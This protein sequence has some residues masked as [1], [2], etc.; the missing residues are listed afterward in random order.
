MKTLLILFFATNTF[1]SVPKMVGK[2][3]ILTNEMEFIYEP[4]E[5]GPS[6]N[7]THFI[8]DASNPY[9]HTV[10]CVEE[11]GV[12][13]EFTAHLALSRYIHPSSPEMSY[14]LLYW[15]NNNGATT[16]FNFDKAASLVNIES[17][18]SITGEEAGLRLKLNLNSVLISKQMKSRKAF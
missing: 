13:H 14:E 9:D 11:K 18:Q 8:S 4:Y 12:T 2:P 7:C 17:S 16:W 1:A 10:K 6:V 3:A 15:V 5:S